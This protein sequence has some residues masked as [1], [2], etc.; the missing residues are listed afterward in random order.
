MIRN[1]ILPLKMTLVFQGSPGLAGQPGKNGGKGGPVLIIFIFISNSFT[2]N[3]K[4]SF[5]EMK[6]KDSNNLKCLSKFLHEETN[7]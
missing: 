7:I 5:Y 6:I 2:W 1:S 4:F 3:R